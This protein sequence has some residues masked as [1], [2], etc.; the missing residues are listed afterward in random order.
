MSLLIRRMEI[1]EDFEK[2]PGNTIVSAFI[3]G[4]NYRE[5]RNYEKYF[6]LAKQLLKIPMNKIIFLDK[7]LMSYFKDY[8]N[9]Y[10]TL[11]AFDKKENYLYD[12]KDTLIN[13]EL[14]TENPSKDTIEYMFTMAYKTE[15]VRKA[16]QI[17]NYNTKH[18]IWMD[19]GIKHMMDHLTQ[20]EFSEKVLRLK[21]L[22]YPDHVRIPS[23]WNPDYDFQIDM[24]K[25]ICW[26]FAGSLFGGGKEKLIE[27]ADLT[28][29]ECLNIIK[30]KKSLM[31]EINVWKLVYNLD[32][33]R[34]LFY[35]CSHDTGILDNY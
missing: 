16:I 5:D 31:W 24:Y 34:F 7:S 9:E 30:Q 19:I 20:Q 18:F 8:V 11:I 15:F 33:W 1:E 21:F 29:N 6:S 32:R 25:D 27:F 14:N 22:E 4:I 26:C 3:T 13:F 17:N 12:L 2:G 10:T 28:K 23:I 35:T